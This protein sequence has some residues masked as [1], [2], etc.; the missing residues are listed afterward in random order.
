MPIL[1][2]TGAIQGDADICNRATVDAP[3]AGV[4]IGPG[5]HITIPADWQSRCIAGEVIPG[6]NSHKIDVSATAVISI[7]VS[8]KANANARIPANTA[9][10]NAVTLANFITKL[11]AGT[12]IPS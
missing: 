8:D 3:V 2:S 9:G 6:C 4:H 11:N 10:A 5:I 1:I 7:I 12:L